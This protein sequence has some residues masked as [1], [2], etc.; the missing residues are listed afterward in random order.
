MKISGAGSHG[1]FPGSRAVEQVCLVLFVT[2]FGLVQ[3]ACLTKIFRCMTVPV[4]DVK[5]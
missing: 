2:A 3:L 4:N 5:D 1:G